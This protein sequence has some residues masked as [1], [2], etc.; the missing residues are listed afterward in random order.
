[1]ALV[2]DLYP[3][4]ALVYLRMYLWQKKYSAYTECEQNNGYT[5]KL[6]RS[7]CLCWLHWKNFSWQ[8]W[9]F[10]RLFKFCTARASVLAIVLSDGPRDKIW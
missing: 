2:L 8:N 10:F 7:V 1:M 9:M 4:L 5:K 3:L 6:R